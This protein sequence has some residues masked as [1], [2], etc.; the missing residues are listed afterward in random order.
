MTQDAQPIALTPGHGWGSHLPA[1]LECVLR[2]TGPV[3]E[4]GAGLWSTPV[5]HAVCEQQ[6]RRLVTV[7][8]G[9]VWREKFQEYMRGWHLFLRSYD[10]ALV[11]AIGWSVALIDHAKDRRQRDLIRLADRAEFL[12]V[13]DANCPKVYGYDF[14]AFTYRREFGRLAPTTMVVSNRREIT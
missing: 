11:D 13:H 2:T 3:L 14:S 6:A 10:A 9:A 7:E 1:L 8:E 12:V 4:M 5:L